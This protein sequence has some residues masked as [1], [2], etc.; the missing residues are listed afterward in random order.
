MWEK[1]RVDVYQNFIEESRWRYITDGLQNTLKITFFAVII[2]ILLGF[3]VAVIRSTY[4]N[5]KKLKLLNAVS[6]S[7]SFFCAALRSDCS[8]TSSSLSA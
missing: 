2:G 1:L 6:Y 3:L 4:E 7:A 5:T 8:N